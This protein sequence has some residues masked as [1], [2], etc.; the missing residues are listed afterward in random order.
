MLIYSYYPIE[1]INKP[2]NNQIFE[3]EK[4]PHENPTLENTFKKPFEERGIKG[5]LD[6]IPQRLMN[7]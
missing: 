6:H 3:I 4:N 7:I 5:E 2:I 1:N